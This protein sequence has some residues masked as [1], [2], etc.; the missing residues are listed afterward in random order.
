MAH[1]F[2]RMRWAALVWLAVWGW[3]YASTWGAWNFLL[4][5]DIAVILTCVGLW[6]GSALLLSSQAVSSLVVDL[7]WT[8]DVAAWL[9]FGRHLIGGT[10]YMWDAQYSLWVRLLSVFHVFWPVLL[11]WSLRHVGYDRRGFLLQSALA[12]VVMLASRLG[13]PAKNLNF[14]FRDPIF[15]RTWGPAP[16]HV[17]LMLGVLVLVLY[18]PTHQILL[19]TLPR[20]GEPR[21]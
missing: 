12:A 4:L 10:E 2:P 7:L 21:S 6:R 19:R 9:V 20:A 3:V 14:V 8:A 15:G 16:A 13:D 18:W 17:A 11:V 5:C 1:E